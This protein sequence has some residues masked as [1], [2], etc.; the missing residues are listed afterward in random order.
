MLNRLYAQSET[1]RVEEGATL[2]SRRRAKQRENGAA[3]SRLRGHGNGRDA[4]LVRSQT[5]QAES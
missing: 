1:L 3:K 4:R 5:R 2:A